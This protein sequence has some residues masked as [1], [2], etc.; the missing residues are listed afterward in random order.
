[1][2]HSINSAETIL[3][4][5]IRKGI[6]D[7]TKM[8]KIAN[9]ESK[10]IV[11]SMTRIADVEQ[12]ISDLITQVSMMDTQQRKKAPYE[13]QESNGRKIGSVLTKDQY[14]KP[15]TYSENQKRDSQLFSDKQLID[16]VR[17]MEQEL[18]CLRK[19]V[20]AANK[21]IRHSAKMQ[22]LSWAIENAR[23]GEFTYYSF[24]SGYMCRSKKLVQFILLNFRKRRAF[25][26][27]SS[28]YTIDRYQHDG[29]QQFLDLLSNQIEQLIGRKPTTYLQE[30]GDYAL[31]Y[32]Y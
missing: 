2:H 14:P 22:V 29:K 3:F 10:S 28:K 30:D 20:N 12:S 8:I 21:E 26:L 6:E 9:S 32:P 13:P 27:V 25:C 7:D 15:M 17:N 31:S 4:Q 18:F 1:M 24:R 5:S 19:E 16:K 23:L 11:T